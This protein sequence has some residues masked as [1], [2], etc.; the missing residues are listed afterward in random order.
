MGLFVIFDDISLIPGWEFHR[1]WGA[2]E[3]V[4]FPDDGSPRSY[5]TYF[6]PVGGFRFGLFTVPPGAG[7]IPEDFDFEKALIEVVAAKKRAFC[8][9]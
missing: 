6:P 9:F 8:L 4:K 7:T 3:R 1:L 5:S 2:D